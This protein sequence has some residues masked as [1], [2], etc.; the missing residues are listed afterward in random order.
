MYD[1]LG[2]KVFLANLKDMELNKFLPGVNEG[3]Y[4]VRVVTSDNSFTQKVYLK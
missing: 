3:Y 2:R 4:M 1:L